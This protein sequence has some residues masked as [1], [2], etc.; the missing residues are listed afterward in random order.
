MAGSLVA[1]TALITGAA[2]RIG[3]SIALSLAGQGVNIV[4]HYRASVNEAD[5]LVHELRNLHVQA[6]SIRADL[7]DE[8]QAEALIRRSCDMAGSLDLLINNA[9]VFAASTISTVSFD[10]LVRQLQINAWAPLLL[11]RRFAEEVGRGQIVNLLDARLQGWDRG[12]VAYYLSKQAL[13]TLT[14]MTALEFAPEIRVN[15]VAPDLILPPPDRG[16]DYLDHL[17]ADVPLKRHGA[18]ENI[19]EAVL[20]LLR[21]E[22]VTGEIIHVDGG[23][24]L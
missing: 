8:R 11:S 5:R 23:R 17:A 9:A 19:A 12:H 7:A 18:P 21:N 10:E 24:Y 4:V 3:R 22:F 2:K 13:A 16:Q 6:W 1:R 15:G 20:F 14:R